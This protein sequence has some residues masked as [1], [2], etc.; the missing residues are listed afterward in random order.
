MKS[1]LSRTI[2]IVFLL[3]LLLEL[4]EKSDGESSIDRTRKRVQP[5]QTDKNDNRNELR[6]KK[7]PFEYRRRRLNQDS[8]R[9]SPPAC[10]YRLLFRPWPLISSVCVLGELS[11]IFVVFDLIDFVFRLFRALQQRRID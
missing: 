4:I 7:H 3:L 11:I 5:F 8:T 6:L 2:L 10:D 1:S 9:R